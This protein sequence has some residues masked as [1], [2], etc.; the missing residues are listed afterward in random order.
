MNLVYLIFGENLSNHIQAYF[1]IFSMLTQKKQIKSINIITDHP[2][3]YN[4]L[5]SIVNIIEIGPND[6]REWQGKYNFFWR[7]KIKAIEQI[8]ETYKNEDLLYLDSDTFLFGDLKYI[9]EKLNDGFSFMHLNEGKLSK[10]KSK[11]E[12]IMW[13]QISNQNIGSIKINESYCMWNAGV[14]GIPGNKSTE[15]VKATLNICDAMLEL[16][17]T[18]RLIEQFAFSVA[19]SE[20]SKLL[21][22][23]NHIGHYWGNKEQWNGIIVNL[24]LKAYFSNISLTEL[25]DS[26][27]SFDYTKIPIKVKISNTRYRLHNLVDKIFPER[28]EKYITKE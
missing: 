21:P 4:H 20:F 24:L 11:T 3:I 1:S 12:K 13:R 19:L 5:S 26:F 18:R 25:I 7:V 17:V 9:K 8:A 28:D 23:K 6:L 22:A 14:I 10:L 16:N 15:L 2:K 27:R